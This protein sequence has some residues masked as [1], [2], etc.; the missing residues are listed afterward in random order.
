MKNYLALVGNLVKFVVLAHQQ[1][2]QEFVGGFVELVQRKHLF[3][4]YL[5]DREA[6]GGAGRGFDKVYQI[7]L[8]LREFNFIRSPI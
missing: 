6:L 7:A 1:C 5:I 4:N 8:E 2:E 3:E